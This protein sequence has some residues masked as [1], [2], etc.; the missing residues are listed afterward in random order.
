M[1]D[2]K[3]GPVA[4]GRALCA[5]WF[6]RM[7]GPLSVPAVVMAVWVSN[8]I[9]KV[10]LGLTAFVCLCTT[11]Y[12]VW[13]KERQ[14]V[15]ELEK[16][17][18]RPELDIKFDPQTIPEC[19]LDDGGP[20][21]QFR[22]KIE[23]YRSGKTIH[24][25]QGRADRVEGPIL[26]RPYVEKVP[27][28]WAIRFNEDQVDLHD[29]EA[30]PLN[31]IVMRTNENGIAVAGFISRVDANNSPHPFNSIG[32]Y[33]CTISVTSDETKPQYIDFTFDWTGDRA[34]AKVK[35]VKVIEQ[36]QRAVGRKSDDSKVAA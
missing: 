7:S 2:G 3:T 17:S 16:L 34:T 1:F 18:V 24:N 22:I 5:D 25:C 21:T 31:V 9:A 6:T 10:L 8:D 28:T 15:I 23:N 19:R 4:F 36:I 29:G 35:D 14:R 12:A 30:L 33:H 27:L 13:R 20:W 11:A 32:E 26:A